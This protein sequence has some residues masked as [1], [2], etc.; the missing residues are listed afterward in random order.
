M[1]FLHVKSIERY[2]P[3]DDRSGREW[4]QILRKAAWYVEVRRDY[5][6]VERMCDKSV[7]ALRKIL[8]REDVKTSY[9]LRI[10]ASTY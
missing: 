7:K 3:T 9:S 5:R 6:E 4:A 2:Q 1:F 8:D 10:L